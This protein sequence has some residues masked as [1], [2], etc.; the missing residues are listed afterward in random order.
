MIDLIKAGYGLSSDRADKEQ[1]YYLNKMR[2]FSP[3]AAYSE[4]GGKELKQGD[5]DSMPFKS[6]NQESLQSQNYDFLLDPD[7]VDSG[8]HMSSIDHNKHN[9]QHAHEFKKPAGLYDYQQP[10]KGIYV[11]ESDEE[12]PQYYDEEEEYE[13]QT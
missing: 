12:E 1:T 7:K 13:D 2:E 10:R 8:S 3:F 5:N 6:G 11:D 4:N 9:S